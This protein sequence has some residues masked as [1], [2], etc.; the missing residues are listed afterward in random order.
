VLERKVSERMTS[1]F[2]SIEFLPFR[3]DNLAKAQYLLTG[4][5]THMQAGEAKGALRLDLALTDLRSG[6]IVAQASALARDEAPGPHAVALLPRQA[7]CS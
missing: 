4:T 6:N 1:K 7:R 2:E 5:M 3:S